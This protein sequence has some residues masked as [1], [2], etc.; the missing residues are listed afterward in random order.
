MKRALVAML[1]IGFGCGGSAS[2][3]QP[4]ADWEPAKQRDIRVSLIKTLV[5]AGAYTT[6]VPL[7]RQAMADNPKDPRL[8]HMLGSVL[9]ERALYDQAIAAFEEAIRL[10][11]KFGEAHS[12]QAMTLNMQGKHDA[13]LALHQKA[14]TLNK[15]DAR[16]LNN[17][18][19]G[20]SLLNR[21]EE[22]VRVYKDALKLDPNQRN[23]YVN[24]GFS[25]AL[26]SKEPEA[27]KAFEQVLKEG[28]VLNNLALARELRG[29]QEGALKL[30]A[31][32]LEVDPRLEVAQDNLDAISESIE[33][34]RKETK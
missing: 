30:Y 14:V 15:D 25:L 19:F 23:T 17:L 5:D 1:L 29:D 20:L 11:P 26:L 21:H 6:S 27:R 7:L 10:A 31:E 2:T 18:G 34:K 24:L 8:H 28:E 33:D 13:A 4:T 9:R 32:A 12:G 3:T 22:A 16:L